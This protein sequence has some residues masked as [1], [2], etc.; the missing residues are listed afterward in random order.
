MSNLD[1]RNK[2]N[3]GYFQHGLNLLRLGVVEILEGL[4]KLAIF[5]TI[6]KE[7]IKEYK[8]LNFKSV[9]GITCDSWTE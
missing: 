3:S 4:E 2:F 9:F 5:S 1:Y 8:C 7:T 6:S